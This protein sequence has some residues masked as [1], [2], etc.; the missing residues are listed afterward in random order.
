MRRWKDG[1]I[2]AKPKCELDFNIETQ[3]EI[4]KILNQE[5]QDTE[6]KCFTGRMN[7]VV[8]CLN[9]FSKLVK[10]EIKSSD[11]IGNIIFLIKDKLGTEYTIDKHKE[12]VKQ[13]ML[14]RNYPEQEIEEW[15]SHIE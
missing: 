14:E 2:K 12:L 1:A 4:K 15:L 10:I 9:G 11:Q 7:R 6:C 13:E 5:I 3:N 8:N